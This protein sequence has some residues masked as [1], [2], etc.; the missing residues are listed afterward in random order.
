MKV[1]VSWLRDYVDFD[2]TPEE[3]AEKLTFSGIEVEGIKTVG[4]DYAG[5]A[6][7]E[8]TAIAPHPGADRLRLCRVD[9]GMEEVAVVCGAFNFDVGDKAPFAPVGTTL[10]NGMKIKRAKIRGEESFGML[11]AEDELGLSDDHSGIMILPRDLEPGTPLAE[12]LGP[13]ET[14]LELEITWNRADCLSMIGIAREVAALCGSKLRL[15]PVEYPETGSA[16]EEYARV[17]IRDPEGCP[18][19]TARVLSDVQIGP[20]PLWMQRR[21]TLAG[22]RP[23]SNVVDITNY[24]LL[25]CG[26]PLH[27]FDHT[28]LTDGQ[29]VVRRAEES[30]KM[31]T[32]DEVERN[33]TSEMVVIADAQR[34]VAL[35]GV[36]GGA[37]TE[38]GDDTRTVLLESASFDPARIHATS[39]ALGL[40]TESSH[41]FERGVDVANLD[42][43]SRR[44]AALMVELAGAKVATGAIDAYPAPEAPLQVACR[45]ERVR[46]RIGVDIPDDDVVAILQSL[47]LPVAGRD[48]KTCTIA[49]PSFRRDIRIEADLV[50]EVARIHGLQDIPEEVPSAVL[51]PGVSDRDTRVQARFRATLI[52][53]GLT[54]A[55][56]YSFLSGQLLDV[57]GADDATRRVVLPHPVSADHDVMR[58]TLVPQMIETLGRNLAR[59]V[60]EVAFFEIGGV[61]LRGEDGAITEE[62]RL[63]IGLMGPIGR[64]GQDRRRPVSREEMFLWAKGILESLGHAMHVPELRF[65]PEKK[66]PFERGWAAS[67]LMGDTRVG[68]LGLIEGRIRHKWR[69]QDAVAVVE[70]SVQ[71][72]VAKSL[73]QR[74]LSPLPAYPS[75]SRDIALVVER[76]IH[77]ADV[78]RIIWASACEEL[79]A[80][81][82][83]DIYE[84]Q[85]MGE[86]KRSLAYSLV[87]RSMKRTLTD[88]EVNEF[89]DRIKDALRA[90]LK[91][92]IRED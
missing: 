6:V 82:L 50:E 5:L 46:S 29:I 91:A 56:H 20:S 11:C 34:P 38:I 49:V 53:L 8:V 3:L 87:Y 86:A 90:E 63:C 84:D 44:A 75:V 71:P 88:D 64:G 2:A 60:D 80:V 19:Y 17:D 39:V 21:L 24:V 69:M 18:R 73:E 37:G 9:N 32:L 41:R 77:H 74:A 22:V 26:Q 59:Q 92:E 67:I 42:W 47:E 85:R 43:A 33:L 13:P 27:A 25:E 23:I 7:G 58:P 1:P 48:E 45:F 78:E 51:V 83:F 55:M 16:V 70:V 52:G 68:E 79:T 30:E 72:V 4:S 28:L 61:F 66:P 10:P 62:D 81:K 35:A 89:H 57:V 65:A 36:M 14:I 15:P 54:E 40:T 12:V 31:A 76:G